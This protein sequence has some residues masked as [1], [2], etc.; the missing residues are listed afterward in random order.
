MIRRKFV[1]L[2]LTFT[3]A[4]GLGFLMADQPPAEL[5]QNEI[6]DLRIMANGLIGKLPDKMPGNEQD[7]PARI[8]LGEKLYFDTLLSTNKAISCNSCHRL[9]DLKAGMDGLPTSPGAFQEFGDRNSPTV[10]N[11]GFQFS[12]FWDGRAASLAEQAKGPVLNPVEM[13]MP[14]EGIVLERIKANPEYPQMFHQAFPDA[15]SSVS[16]D[17]VAEAIAAFER[18]LITHDRFDDFLNGKN[19]ALNQAELKGFQAFMH[20]G[21]VTCHNGPLLGGNTYQKIGLQHPYKNKED[22][23]R[24]TVTNDEEDKYKFKVPTLR[25]IA[26]TAPYMHDGSV[27][28]LGEVVRQMAWMQLDQ[29]L[30]DE[31]AKAIVTFLHSLTDKQRAASRGSL[32]G[33]GATTGFAAR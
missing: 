18:T 14:A 9:D 1:L 26:L 12:Q 30:K 29:L 17:N 32:I 24:Y 27:F 3:A 28:T 15:E 5:T 4:L 11:A 22:L 16:Y 20:V 25:N 21:C 8:A 23:G 31:Q 2:T 6:A 13:G 10:L 7:T 33:A 19:D